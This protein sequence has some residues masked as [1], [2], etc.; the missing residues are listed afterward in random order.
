MTDDTIDPAERIA[1]LQARRTASGRAPGTARTR[2]VD[3]TTA[4]PPPGRRAGA[5]PRPGV[6]AVA[7]PT[8][9]RPAVGCS[10]G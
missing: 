9:R 5:G 10:A 1:R 8:R 2:T 3:G 6:G 7:D 4:S